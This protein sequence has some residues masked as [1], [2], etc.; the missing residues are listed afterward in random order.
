MID[1]RAVIDPG[2]HLD[3]GVTVGPWSVIGPNVQIG[4]ETWIGPHVVIRGPTRIGKQNRV[5][6]FCSIGD[7]SQD[8][9]YRGEAEPCLEIGDGNT[10]REF[11]TLN[12]GTVQGGGITRVGDHNWIMAYVHI[13]HDCIVG[14]NT[15]FANNA[16]LAGHVIVDDYV[17]LGGFA[18]AH[19]YCHIG[20][21]SFAA[22]SAVITKDVPPYMLVSDNPAR[23]NGVNREGLRRNGFAPKTIDFLRRAYKIVYRQNLSTTAA[24]ERLEELLPECPEIGCLIDFLRQSSRGIVR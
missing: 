9:K 14:S 18:G 10:I 5:F 8:K 12:R 11:C 6:Q 16:S 7:D 4:K 22:I 19:Q 24:I 20:A 21:Y 13:A 3:E 2:A 23:A 17:I 1:S 15:V